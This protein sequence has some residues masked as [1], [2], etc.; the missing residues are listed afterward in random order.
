MT[1]PAVRVP[2]TTANLGPG[3]DAFGAAL[4]RYLEARTVPRDDARVVTTGEG[5]GEVADDDGNL[6]WRALTDGCRH[7]GISPPDVSLR[8]HNDVPLERGL[9][10]SS[11]AIVAGLGLARALAGGRF[12]DLELARAAT[13]LEGHADNV[14]PAVT[15]GLTCTASGDDGV[16]VV[17][18]AQPTPRLSPVTFVPAERQRTDAA[19]AVLPERLERAA[20]ATQAGRAGH[21]LGALLGAWPAAPALA[22]DLL[23]EPPRLER[24]GPSGALLEG[25]RGAGVHAWLSGAGPAVA[26]A[27]PARARGLVDTCH[28]LGDAHG[29]GVR[30]HAWDLGG[31]VT[32]WEE[33]VA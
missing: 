25:L 7:L 4:S 29:F 18:R 32:W 26:A 8:V 28:R 10:S 20:V 19:R 9:G 22:G 14:V 16:P 2:A 31:L 30:V 21:V 15:G 24:M 13:D 6:V 11:A 17:R 27:V 5:V 1:F 12:S 3:F 23:H 33:P